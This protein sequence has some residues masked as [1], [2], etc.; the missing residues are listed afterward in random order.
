MV[1]YAVQSL[2]T[3][4][5]QTEHCTTLEWSWWVC[6]TRYH[7][8]RKGSFGRGGVGERDSLVREKGVGSA[9]GRDL[10]VWR[11]ARSGA[12]HCAP[13]ATLEDHIALEMEPSG[14]NAPRTSH[15][16]CRTF[17]RPIEW[18]R[19]CHVYTLDRNKY[20]RRQT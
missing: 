6:D 11:L 16:K 4:C 20:M 5:W 1:G 19:L 13:K 18:V 3:R 8:A 12:Q 17:R 10:S 9:T 14:L 7:R 15:S 2:Q